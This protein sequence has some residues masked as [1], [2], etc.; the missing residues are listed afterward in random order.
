MPP[1]VCETNGR[2]SRSRISGGMPGPLSS[3]ATCTVPFRCASS[4]EMR[5]PSGVA[6]NAFESRFPTTCST[7][8]P[9][10]VITGRAC[11]L[12]AVVDRPAPRLLAEALVR[13]VDELPHVDLLRRDREAV[14]V[15]LREIEDVA[16][17]PLEPLRLAPR[18]SRATPRARP[19]RRRRLRG[20]PRRG[21][22]SRSAA[23]AARARPTSGSC[24][25]SPRPRRA[26]PPSRRTAR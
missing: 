2:K 13:L 16:D 11:T 20:A 8:S 23:C 22:G 4:S 9:S 25:P 12:L 26:A 6:W 14:R 10:E 18:P 21:R 7:R 3:T 15:E 24:A 1:P 17:E 19:G 5:P